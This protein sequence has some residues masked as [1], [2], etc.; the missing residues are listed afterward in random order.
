MRKGV[1]HQSVRRK[2]MYER[3][4]RLSNETILRTCK[5]ENR[6]IEFGM[7]YTQTKIG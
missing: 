6:E 2:H 1:I 5:C 3:M 7:V 4:P